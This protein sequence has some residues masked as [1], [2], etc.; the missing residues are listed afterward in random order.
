[1]AMLNYGGRPLMPRKIHIYEDPNVARIF[2]INQ[3]GRERGLEMLAR[4]PKK[5]RT[6]SLS[7]KKRHLID[8]APIALFSTRKLTAEGARSFSHNVRMIYQYE[9]GYA[10][11][12][13]HAAKKPSRATTKE[14]ENG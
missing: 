1:L 5:E 7:G 6:Y 12:L 13:L 4:L 9:R 8:L 10:D 2:L 3:Y 14:S 11:G